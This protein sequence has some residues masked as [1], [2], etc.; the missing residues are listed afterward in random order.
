M[1]DTKTQIARA[2]QV[3]EKYEA[4]LLKKNNVVGVGIGFRHKAGQTTDEVAIIVNVKAK[5]PA[6]QLTPNDLLPLLL[7]GIPVDVVEVGTFSIGSVR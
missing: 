6:S 4:V 2:Q 7:D 3:K 1:T 5:M